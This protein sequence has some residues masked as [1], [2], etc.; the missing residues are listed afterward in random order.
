MTSTQGTLSARLPEDAFLLTPSSISPDRLEPS[1]L[2]RVGLRRSGLKQHDSQEALHAAL[3]RAHPEVGAVA[4]GCGENSA[5]FGAT[6][7]PLPSRTIPE[8]YILI[9]E[10]VSVSFRETI[11]DPE[12]VA[13]VISPDNPVAL[14]HNDGAL[15]L[16]ASVL[17]AFDRLEVLEATAAAVIA[18]RPLG[19]LAPMNDQ[20][21]FELRNAFFPSG[22][23]QGAPHG[24]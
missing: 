3:Y 4:H 22:G 17:D 1:D 13:A 23:F 11:V 2:L 15:T 8:S 14:V 21:L 9:R 6:E 24:G 7:I 10:P 19:G 20:Q 18:S 16:G 12:G 5:A